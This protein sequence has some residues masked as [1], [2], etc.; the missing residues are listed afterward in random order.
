MDT[1]VTGRSEYQAQSK[2][3]GEGST[4]CT[5]PQDLKSRA[6]GCRAKSRFIS[7]HSTIHSKRSLAT[8]ESRFSP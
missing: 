6:N 3:G 1:V 8:P 5:S 4:S 2:I 7:S